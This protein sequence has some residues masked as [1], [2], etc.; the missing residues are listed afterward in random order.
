MLPILKQ[1]KAGVEKFLTIGR[2]ERI[3]FLSV[4]RVVEVVV[5][6]VVVTGVVVVEVVVLGE[7]LE[8]LALWVGLVL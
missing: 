6:A 7:V 4:F 5:V 8:T 1:M 2:Q 3:L